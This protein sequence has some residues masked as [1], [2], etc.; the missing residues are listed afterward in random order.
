MISSLMARRVVALVG[1]AA[2]VVSLAAGT[3]QAQTS[4]SAPRYAADATSYQN[5]VIATAMARTP[6]G[7]RVSP[8]EVTWRGGS[9]ILSV[10][11]SAGASAKIADS[12]DNPGGCPDYYFCIW[13]DADYGGDGYAFLNAPAWFEDHNEA[14]EDYWVPWGECGEYPGCDTGEHSWANESGFRTW[15]EQYPDSGHEQCISGNGQYSSDFT[16]PNALDYWVLM[17]TNSAVC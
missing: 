5:A 10:P 12:A 1:C 16:G 13:P 4:G 7:T 2:V 6:G 9:V 11:T 15:L 14:I 3:A 17:T 8:S